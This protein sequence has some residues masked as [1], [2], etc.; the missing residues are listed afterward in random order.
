MNNSLKWDPKHAS[1]IPCGSILVA[2]ALFLSQAQ[3]VNVLTQHNDLARTGANT[4]E[5]ILTPANVN[6][7]NFGKIFTDTVDGQVY[8]QPLYVENLTL[9]TG[10]YNVVFVCTENNSV[11]A[12]D[13]D[14][15]GIIHWKV[16]LG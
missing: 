8:A 7:A 9:P 1:R 13:A 2:T 15:A 6:S 12:F 16:N 14:R 3:A 5:T 4:S 11:Y 10:T